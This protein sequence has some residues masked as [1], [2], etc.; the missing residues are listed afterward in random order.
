[1]RVDYELSVEELEKLLGLLRD[2]CDI[3]GVKESLSR[4]VYDRLHEKYCK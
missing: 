4:K 1:M 3:S 2:I